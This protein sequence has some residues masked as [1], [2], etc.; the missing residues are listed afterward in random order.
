MRYFKYRLFQVIWMLSVFIFSNLN[1]Q[2]LSNTGVILTVMSGTSA[3]NIGAVNNNSGTISN[4]GTISVLG[5]LTNGGNLSGNGLLNIGG[6]LSNSGTFTAGSGTVNFN[7][8]AAQTI[9]PLS[10]NNLTISNSTADCLAAGSLIINGT[11]SLPVGNLVIGSN[12]LTFQTGNTPITRVAGTLTTGSGSSLVFG[13]AGNTG[14]AAFTI[15]AGIFITAPVLDNLT[16]NRINNL[17]L[18]NQLISLRG[19]L[20]CNGPLITNDKLVFLA[21]ATKTAMI[22]GAGTGTVF[23]NVTMQGYLPSGYGYKYLSSPFQAATVNELAAE[24]NLAAPFPTVY[25]YDQSLLSA[26]WVKYINPAGILNPLE[27]YAVNF[28]VASAPKIIDMTGVVN[29]SLVSKV[30]FNNNNLYTLGFSLVGNPYPSPINWN[31]GAG[32]IKTNIDNALYFFNASTTDQYGGTYSSYVNGISSDGGISSNIIPAMQGFFVHVTNGTFPVSGSLTINNAARTNLFPSA[33]ILKGKGDLLSST[34]ANFRQSD[35]S[36]SKIMLRLQAAYEQG[37][38]VSDPAVIYFDDVATKKFDKEYDALK[39]MNTDKAVPNLYTIS[40]DA[41]NLSIN[42]LPTSTD[43]VSTIP[44]GIKTEQS[45][46]V[47]FSVS[48]LNSLPY[49]LKVYFQDAQAKQLHDLRLDPNYRVQLIAGKFDNRFS[50]LFSLKDIDTQTFFQNSLSAFYSNGKLV[51]Q[52]KG[53][54]PNSKGSVL[55]SNVGGQI[56]NRSNF[57]GTDSHEIQLVL[58]PGIYIIS[59]STENGRLSKKIVVN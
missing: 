41:L 59:T 13:T 7:G 16:V 54:Q 28:G 23:G 19:N 40:S 4:G 44:V 57:T 35:V 51:Y 25:S 1:A 55:V 24:V 47:N 21:D 56:L 30:L 46:F 2:V 12:V 58:I 53:I 38:L 9:S 31:T 36:D 50:L 27:G 49:G 6:N 20:L 11:L 45:G 42:A 8:I 33:K 18:G 52:L 29:N 26:G 15:P 22:D 39:L 32:W 10:F 14:G 3:G 17:T 43:S 37:S 34:T 48:H 5:N